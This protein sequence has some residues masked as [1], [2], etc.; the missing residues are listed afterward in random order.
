MKPKNEGKKKQRERLNLVVSRK[1][2]EYHGPGKKKNSILTLID[3]LASP[4]NGAC[5]GRESLIF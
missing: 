2:R 3:I 1:T 4:P 5:V